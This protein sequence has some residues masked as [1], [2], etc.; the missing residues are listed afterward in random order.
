MQPSQLSSLAE[1][2]KSHFVGFLERLVEDTRISNRLS[3]FGLQDCT[4][5]YG[6]AGQTKIEKKKTKIH[7]ESQFIGLQKSPLKERTFASDNVNISS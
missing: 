7:T 6:L 2:F 4:N 1:S 5:S 3:V